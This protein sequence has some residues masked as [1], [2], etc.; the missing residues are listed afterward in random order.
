M[1]TGLHAMLYSSDAEATRAFLRDVL[2]LPATDVGEG[3]LIFRAPAGEIGSHPVGEHPDGMRPGSHEI[4]F[5]TDDVE[6]AVERLKAKGVTCEPVEDQG[7]GIVTR[8]P[9]PGGIT[10]Q[11]YQPRYTLD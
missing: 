1:I 3:W 11:L 10:V 4:S 9:I 7:W 5:T 2:E 6:D 8:F